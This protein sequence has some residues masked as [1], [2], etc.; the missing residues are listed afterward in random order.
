M[1]VFLDDNRFPPDDSWIWVMTARE[2]IELLRAGEV[3]ELDLDNDLGAPES[4]GNGM[5]VLTWIENEM[6][7]NGFE[8]PRVITAHSG[9]QAARRKMEEVIRQIRTVAKGP[10]QIRK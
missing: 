7:V 2:A 4:F 5:E 6:K 3:E 9:D 10:W 8:G 1:K